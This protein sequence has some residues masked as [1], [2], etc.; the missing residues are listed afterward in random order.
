MPKLNFVKSA[1]KTI[2]LNGSYV[3]YVSKKGKRS[4]QTLNKTDKTIP[5]DKNDPVLIAKGESYYWWQFKNNPKIFSKTR[6]KQSQLTQSSYLSELYTIEESL[7]EFSAASIEDMDAGVQDFQSQLEQLRDQCQ[8]SLDNMPESLQSGPTG[9]LLQERIDCLDSAIDEISSI[10]LDYEEPTLE[11][12]IAEESLEDLDED[13]NEWN[14]DDADFN[15]FKN[16][17]LE[18]WVDEKIEELKATNLQ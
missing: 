7:A 3:S 17:H 8:T 12:W 2:Y 15:Y 1:M 11:E 13:G 6:P 5:K 10:D 18:E 16:N 9:E 14:E 4:G